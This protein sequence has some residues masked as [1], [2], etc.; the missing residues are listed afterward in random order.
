M[1]L[2]YANG[3]YARLAPFFTIKRPWAPPE[4]Q[5]LG[6][7]SKKLFF[8]LLLMKMKHK[9]KHKIE[10][11]FLEQNGTFGELCDGLGSYGR[12]CTHVN[13][14]GYTATLVACGWAGA[15]KKSKV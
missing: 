5:K 8:N 2:F 7:F 1:T 13:E 12:T 14:A 3:R 6:F 10:K 4:N 9:I 15:A 11:K